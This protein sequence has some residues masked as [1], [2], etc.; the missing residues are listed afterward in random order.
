MATS[1]KV[2]KIANGKKKR[3]SLMATLGAGANPHH[4]K[5]KKHMANKSKSKKKGGAAHKQN[6]FQFIAKKKGGGKGH[7]K[8]GR[9]RSSNPQVTVFGKPVSVMELLKVLLGGVLGVAGTKFFAPLIPIDQSTPGVKTAVSAA[10]AFAGGKAA[11]QINTEFG[12]GYAFGG[13][14]HATSLGL[15]WI[16]PDVA[17]RAGISGGRG[18]GQYIAAPNQPVPYNPFLDRGM[19]T[20]VMSP[21]A[22]SMDPVGTQMEA[23]YGN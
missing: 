19:P 23:L 15:N 9:P 2:S 4:K 22:S 7:H 13:M 21:A 17:T 10:V 12:Y 18:V 3:N 1:L 8:H 20:N 16:V 14:M 6:G 5:E 11:E